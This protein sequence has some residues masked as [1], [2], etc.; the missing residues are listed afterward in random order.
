MEQLRQQFMQQ[1]QR[2]DKGLRHKLG[3]VPKVVAN[4]PLH[5]RV[6]YQHPTSFLLIDTLRQFDQLNRY[7]AANC[8]KSLR[9]CLS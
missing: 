3:L 5:M 4:H 1:R 2:I 9:S 6:A 8:L 7:F